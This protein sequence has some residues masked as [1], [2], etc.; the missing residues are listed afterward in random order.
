MG[1]SRR[2]VEREER[3]RLR[4]LLGEIKV[5]AEVGL[6]IRTAA[7]STTKKDLQRDLRYLL[8]TWKSVQQ[9][10][11]KASA[12]ALL[13]E[14]LGLVIRSIRDSL[15]T[16]VE[17]I[18]VDSKP[19][20]KKISHFLGLFSRQAQSKIVLY[21]GT[22]PLFEKYGLEKEVEKL[23]QPKIWLKC[24]GYVV[25]N[26]TEALIAVDVNTGKHKGKR[27]QEQTALKANLEAAEEVARQLRLRNL[28]GIIVIDFIDMDSKKHQKQVMSVLLKEFKKDK[29][30]TKVLPF[31]E[32]G[33]VQMTRQ[34]EEE[35]FLQ[36]VCEPCFYCQ[37]LGVIKS[38]SSLALEVERKL[39]AAIYTHQKIK[40]FRIEANPH[41]ARYL[42]E[43]GWQQLRQLAG[44]HRIRLS[45]IDNASLGFQQY[46][47][48]ALT[49]EG[50]EKV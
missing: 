20:Y 22:Q 39:L 46:I 27:D 25:F 5:P 35:S 8:N 10:E 33:L 6:I 50:Q 44:K 14:E 12:P 32:F 42:L 48:W 1:I 7:L 15:L 13:H 43:E 16:D 4:S 37:G 34:R 11:K 18:V 21:R 24:G 2:I 29:A 30:K 23:F 28:G 47:I 17:Q 31:S 38:L 19:E 49:P 45:I 3:H 40:R 26:Q 41:L 36:K 9:Q